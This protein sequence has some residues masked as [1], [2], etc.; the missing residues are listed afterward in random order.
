MIDLEAIKK[1]RSDFD[2]ASVKQGMAIQSC[3]LPDLDC[4]HCCDACEKM[5][6]ADTEFWNHIEDDEADLIEEV[7]R[8]QGEL[9]KYVRC[10]DEDYCERCQADEDLWHKEGE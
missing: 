4:G 6:V 10:P 9:G 1:R 7:E 8:L 2:D 5:D 3:T